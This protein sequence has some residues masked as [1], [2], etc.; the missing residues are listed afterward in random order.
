MAQY[1]GHGENGNLSD[2]YGFYWERFGVRFPTGA[3]MF[4]FTGFEGYAS[5]L[6]RASSH[7]SQEAISATEANRL[8]LFGEIVAVYCEVE[9]TFQLTVGRSVSQSVSMSRHRRPPSCVTSCTLTPKAY[10][11]Y[12]LQSHLATATAVEKPAQVPEVTDGSDKREE[13]VVSIFHDRKL[14]CK[15]KACFVAGR[16]GL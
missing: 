16:E 4:L 11:H 8:M 1:S 6:S 9:V 14:Q 15:S 5:P 12:Y 2:G 10:G 13:E 3:E 7:T